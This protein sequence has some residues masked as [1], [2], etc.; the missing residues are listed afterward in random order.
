M[1]VSPEQ[2]QHFLWT[3]LNLKQ[4][5][6]DQREARW[7]LRSSPST[8]P[9][10]HLTSSRPSLAAQGFPTPSSSAGVESD[11]WL[12]SGD[13]LCFVW[14]NRSSTVTNSIKTLKMVHLKKKIVTKTHYSKQTTSKGKLYTLT[15]ALS[16]GHRQEGQPVA[17]K[18]G[19][20]RKWA[21]AAVLSVAS[22]QKSGISW[23]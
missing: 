6:P 23:P 11:P 17:N 12:R 7:C 9:G 21:T 10:P 13:P 20:Q 8:S 18:H 1:V 16:G 3:T 15:K 5:F 2:P 4:A 19:K 22:H 14:E